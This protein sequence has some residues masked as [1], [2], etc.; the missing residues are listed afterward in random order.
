MLKL[1]SLRKISLIAVFILIFA[2]VLPGLGKKIAAEKEHVYLMFFK[3][4][5][6]DFA[7]KYKDQD[8]IVVSKKDHLLYYYKNGRLVRDD[9]WNGFSFDFPVKVS[10][11]DKWHRTPEGEMYV[12]YKNKWSHYT[13]FLSLSNPGDYGIHGAPT[14]LKSYLNKMEKKNPDL[15]FVTQKDDTRGCVAVENRVIKYLFAQVKVGTPVLIMQ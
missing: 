4:K 14:H 11:A 7:R 5:V 12:D 2:L 6:W 9:K 1:F 8:V 3:Q 13:L 15:V 10:L